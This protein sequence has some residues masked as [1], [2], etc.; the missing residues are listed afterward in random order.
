MIVIYN[1]MLFFWLIWYVVKS[2][3]LLETGA[4]LSDHKLLDSS[5]NALPISLPGHQFGIGTKA[6]FV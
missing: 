2:A 3:F 5:V 6:Y 1:T 4:F